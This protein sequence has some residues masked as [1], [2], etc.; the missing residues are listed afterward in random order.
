MKKKANRPFVGILVGV[1]LFSSYT[2]GAQIEQAL[3]SI[4]ALR[5][6]SIARRELG[7]QDIIGMSVGV[8]RQGKVA[9][10][11]GYGFSDWENRVP[12]GIE[13]EFR[14]ASMSKSL[15]SIAALKLREQGLLDLDTVARAYV[16]N[17]PDSA[18]LVR[19]LLQNRS[20]IG[21]YNEMDQLYPGWKKK[22][23]TYQPDTLAWNA[24]AAVEL[25][26]EAPL[27]FRPDSTY[28]YTT[29]GFVL[30]GAVVDQIGHTALGMG[31]LDMVNNYV[32]Q[33]LGLQSLKPDY[34]FDAN[35][36]EV[37]GYYRNFAGDIRPRQDD[38]ISWKIPGGGYASNII[39]LTKYVQGLIHRKLMAPESYQTLWERQRDRDYALGFEVKGEGAELFVA[40]TGSQNKTR[41]I[42]ACYPNQGLGVAV[43]C[44]TEWA[45]PREVAER[46]LEALRH[47][48]EAVPAA[49]G[50]GK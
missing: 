44:N 32:V 5:L 18:I 23:E 49:T 3:D 41:T 47:S 38:D 34:T 50:Q 2:A 40:H 1:L 33:P 6:D 16:P 27:V 37:K 28:L 11:K 29:F 25:F 35:P 10:L 17:W 4:L 13:S 22:M 36:L 26:R 14:W 12:V 15:T 45:N 19:H 24:A 20:G 21:H 8:V 31:Y 7:R 39:D 9:F 30:A 46:L 43:M 42:F 48:G